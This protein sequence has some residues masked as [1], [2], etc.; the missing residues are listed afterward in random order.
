MQVMV[1]CAAAPASCP[2]DNEQGAMYASHALWVCAGCDERPTKGVVW[3]ALLCPVPPLHPQDSPL[4][5]WDEAARDVC[6]GC[7]QVYLY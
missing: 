7:Q 1:A 4:L 2:H 5:P 3:V 6:E